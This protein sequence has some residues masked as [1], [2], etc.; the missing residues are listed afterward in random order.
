MIGENNTK[1]AI[2]GLGY[3]GLP[4]ARLFAT[5]YLTI[6]FDINKERITQLQSGFDKTGELDSEHLKAVLINE[7]S[8]SK[9][10]FCTSNPEDL[11]QSD[12]YIITVTGCKYSSPLIN[13]ANS[14]IFKFTVINFRAV[15]IY[16]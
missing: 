1:I 5:K 2:I 10:L 8:A 12:T 14:V 16:K 11:Q 7:T 13:T 4:L 3:V 9:G 6:G 15:Y